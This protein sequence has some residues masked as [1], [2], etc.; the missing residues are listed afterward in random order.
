MRT[1][2]DLDMAPGASSMLNACAGPV[3][4]FAWQVGHSGGD[5][6]KGTADS[7]KHG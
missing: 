3:A 2:A 1:W 5:N 6:N 4:L 7:L